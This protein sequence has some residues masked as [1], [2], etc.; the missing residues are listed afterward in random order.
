M[1]SSIFIYKNVEKKLA[2]HV[3][4]QNELETRAWEIALRAEA[5]L[6]AHKQ[7][8]HAQILLMRGDVDHY[9]VL[10]DTRGMDA[11]MSIEF[12]RAGYIDP[13][14]G[15]VYGAMEP[16]YILTNAASLPKKKK[17]LPIVRRRLRRKRKGVT[18]IGRDS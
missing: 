11:A 10:D 4:V 9:V 5:E 2:N 18:E 7:D 17:R 8:G 14:T 1:A 6:V 16:L 12:G 3:E 15:I 13:E